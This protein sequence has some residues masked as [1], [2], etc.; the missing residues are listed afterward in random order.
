MY[1]VVIV[2]DE[3]IVSRG[4]SEKVDWA[5]LNCMVC[6]IGNNG[7]EGKELVDRYQP[8]I[9]MTDI[10]MPGMSGLELAEYIN[11]NYPHMVSILL[12]GYSEFEYAREA[13]RHQVFDYLL[14]PIELHDLHACIRRAIE[15]LD[16][17]GDD[18]MK[19]KDSVNHSVVESGILLDLIVNGNK[20][21]ASLR[22]KM[23][24][25]NINFTSGQTVVF[26]LYK[27]LDSTSDESSSLSQFATNNILKETFQNF[28]LEI[29]LINI[30]NKSVVIVKFDPNSEQKSAEEQLVEVTNLCQEN[31]QLYLNKKINA[32]IGKFFRDVDELNGSFKSA[33]KDLET[34]IFWGKNRYHTQNI[35]SRDSFK[36]V[37]AHL[38]PEH[39]QVIY[40][41]DLNESKIFIENFMGKIRF[42]RDKNFALNSCLDFLVGLLK[43]IPDWQAKQNITQAITSI[44]SLRTFNEYNYEM[45]RIVELVCLEA[46]QRN[47]DLKATLLDQIKMY[48][49]TH[50]HEPNIS[51]QYIAEVFH[52]STSHLSRL[53]K[54]ETGVNF[55]EFLTKKR[56]ERA[57][58]LLEEDHRMSILEIAN[59]VGFLDGKYFGQVFKKYY[60]YTPS[61][62]KEIVKKSYIS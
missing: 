35:K 48:L 28:N 9:L 57:R 8:D 40:E 26:E 54:K 56:V 46:R 14:K 24:Q 12:S 37:A 13:V 10:K 27:P 23:S 32:G 29:T 3:T 36:K 42:Y 2:D 6:A 1:K 19:N 20:D 22:E 61:D 53:F 58:K 62:Y 18:D 50:Y 16:S 33:I 47:A 41:G 39:F 44:P 59:R 45:I 43:V 5:E 30:E 34:H 25:F 21:I 55:S 11:R 51:L 15:Q 38:S 49:N 7:M 17:S 31:I 60:G 4:L 52:V